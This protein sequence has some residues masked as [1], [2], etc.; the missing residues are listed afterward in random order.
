MRILIVDDNNT[1][2]ELLRVTLAAEGHE[3]VEAADG[4]EAF[5]K[6]HS[7]RLDAVITDILMPKMDG[8]QLCFKIRRSETFRDLPIV[9]YSSTYTSAS[10]EQVALRVGAD[11]F[12]RK[13]P[14]PDSSGE[15]SEP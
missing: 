1:N 11:R 14:G 4:V 15:V 8:Y 3:V 12:L 9:I 6:L 7:G 2:R 13:P 10:D 5:E